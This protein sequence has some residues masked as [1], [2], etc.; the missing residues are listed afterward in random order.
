M[1]H[2]LLSLL[3]AVF[4]AVPLSVATAQVPRTFT[5]QG[6][7]ID[8]SGN[9]I[10]DGLHDLKI[11]I[12][13]DAAATTPIYTEDQTGVVF[14]KGI[15]NV[16]V[17]SKTVIP[18]SLGFDKGY[19]LGV[20]VDGGLEMTPR[21]AISPAPYSMFSQ[22]S[23]GLVPDAFGAVT[24]L[25]GLSGNLT[26]EAGA[27]LS[28]TNSGSTITINAANGTGIGTEPTT[29]YGKIVDE[30]GVP[31]AGA[32]VSAGTS[33]TLTNAKGLYILKNVSVPKGRAIVIAKKTGYFNGAKAVT[34]SSDGTSRIELSM[35]SNAATA[36]IA[37][38]ATGGTVNITGGGSIVF[39]G[40][41]FTTAGGGPYSGQ[42][43][44]SA[45]YLDPKNLSFFDYFPGDDLAQNASGNTVS[46][47]S[48]G[49]LRVE[50]KDANG[51]QL[52][53]DASKP[54]K[55]SF[56]KP[57]DTKAPTTM[58]LWYFDESLG[59]WKEE[60]TATLT[61]G[62]YSGN[63]THFTTWNLDYPGPSRGTVSL[64]VVC[65]GVPISG[66]EVS[67]V[68]DNTSGIFYIHRGGMTGPD[69]RITFINFPAQR[70]T[71]VLIESAKNNGLYFITAPIDIALTNGQNLNL[72]DISLSSA[73]PASLSGT[74]E[75]N[76]T[77]VEGLVSVTDGTN[78]AYTYTTT[79]DFAL[80]MPSGVQL[81]VGTISANGDS[82]NTLV[83]PALT[84]GQQKNIGNVSLCG[85]STTNYTEITPT[86]YPLAIAL[87]PDGSRLGIGGTT[88]LMVYDAATGNVISSATLSGSSFFSNL[89]FSIDGSKLL[90]LNRDSVSGLSVKVYNVSTTTATLITSIVGITG[91][92]LYDDG[93]KIIAR[94]NS[95]PTKIVIYSAVDGSIIK[96]LNPVNISATDLDFGFIRSEDAAIYQD[97]N[98][99]RVWDVATDVQLRFFSV[100]G[101]FSYFGSS[102]DGLTVSSSANGGT[103]SF[104]NTQSG[105]KRGDVTTNAPPLLTQNYVYTVTS[106]SGIPAVKIIHIANGTSSLR[107]MGS[108]VGSINSIAAS[109]DEK[110]LAVALSNGKVRI[111]KIN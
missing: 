91:A 76:G 38:A 96:T 95:N 89:Q 20:T 24:S 83:V 1:R 65:G 75:C 7:V 87:S 66:V 69:G 108:G 17:G 62:V 56:P 58:P 67:V 52:K 110:Y 98:T 85:S 2:F 36:T 102:D 46:L 25:N 78:T 104:Y 86:Q 80:Q 90:V 41:S 63:V 70:P 43:K 61:G 26:F 100:V 103:Y 34:P 4:F 15:F 19:F 3:F 77:K 28:I 79:G 48:G 32:T 84:A 9:F 11:R 111:L 31:V 45:R 47:I 94:P 101:G 23:G 33:A 64:R 49:A 106:V 29:I 37:S 50:I 27:G 68:V 109:R 105:V 12:Y 14:V 51:N 44:V 40:G 53:L 92:K 60:G 93:T 97:G 18:A 81:N 30:T 107:L 54:A 82:A 16:V 42:V 8:A 39:A 99:A 74:L 73:C 21:T 59:M 35:M 6:V 71:Q 57:I 10:A 88:N 22:S 5:Y 55:L 72:G 13:D